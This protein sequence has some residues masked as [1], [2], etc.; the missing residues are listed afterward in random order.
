MNVWTPRIAIVAAATVAAAAAAGTAL[1]AGTSGWLDAVDE[2]GQI[3]DQQAVVGKQQPAAAAAE[4]DW[5]EALRLRSEAHV[6]G[7]RVGA[8]AA[9]DPQ[10]TVEPVWLR[11]LRLR[12]EALD[13]RYGL[14]R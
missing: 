7:Q 10:A 13:R 14:G 8:V 5:Q 12:S 4:P 6:R 3:L 9:A 11:A 1:T 2:H